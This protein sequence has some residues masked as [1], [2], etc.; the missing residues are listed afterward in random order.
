MGS[1]SSGRSIRTSR[2]SLNWAKASRTSLRL[3]RRRRRPRAREMPSLPRL[4]PART[5]L[6]LPDDALSLILACFKPPTRSYARYDFDI[7][8]ACRQSCSRLHSLVTPI[9]FSRKRL[10][11][12]NVSTQWHRLPPTLRAV[13][14]LHLR[15]FTVT[16]LFQAP[17]SGARLA[18]RLQEADNGR[19]DLRDRSGPSLEG[20]LRSSRPQDPPA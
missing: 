2:C 5:L 7:L 9:L 16:V 8:A 15:T 20:A 18:R 13:F 6:S 3:Y 11:N 12:N 10:C 19:V 1:H 17:V 4:R 14:A